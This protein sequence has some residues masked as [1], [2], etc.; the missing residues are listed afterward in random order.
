M[1]QRWG[2]GEA[3][4]SSRPRSSGALLRA[5]KLRV[6]NLA[7]S[8]RLRTTYTWQEVKRCPLCA[9]TVL[10]PS[11]SY[12]QGLLGLRFQACQE[13]GLVVQSPRL[14]SG[15]LARYYRREYRASLKRGVDAAHCE[16]LFQRGIRRGTYIAGFLEEHGVT[17]SG[18]QV[19]E[20][21]CA[22]GGILAYFQSRGCRVRGCDVSAV[23]VAYGRSRGLDLAVGSVE[24][25]QGSRQQVDL[26]ILS[27]VLEHIEEPHAFL[28]TV[29]HALASAGV[30]YVE[31]PGL[32]AAKDRRRQ[33]LQ[34]GHLMHFRLDNLRRLLESAG[35]SFVAGNEVV[36]A[37]FRVGRSSAGK[38]EDAVG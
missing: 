1:A 16:P 2:E 4:C 13:C 22:Y 31:V 32:A 36:Q 27:H 21:G 37:L 24:L 28:E 38:P 7:Q 25:L 23:A 20:V 35:F 34:L 11:A 3:A 33:F 6:E 19:Y 17:L 14:T 5:A 29:R 9:G 10:L 18:K 15:S 30:L 12:R 26:L 8:L